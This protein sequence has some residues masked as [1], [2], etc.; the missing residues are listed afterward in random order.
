MRQ[1]GAGFNRDI[2][3]DDFGF[4]LG[5]IGGIESSAGTAAQRARSTPRSNG[6]AVSR[7]SR[8]GTNSRSS[9]QE[10]THVDENGS[11]VKKRKL[12]QTQNVVA[13]PAQP[14]ISGIDAAAA[15]ISSQKASTGKKRGKRRK[16]I[17]QSS[18]NRKRSSVI[19][20]SPVSGANQA[21][22]AQVE[23]PQDDAGEALAGDLTIRD[24]TV[25]PNPSDN[26]DQL[27]NDFLVNT[28]GAEQV[29]DADSRPSDD[30]TMKPSWRR[31][32]KARKSTGGT[33]KRPLPSKLAARTERTTANEQS[34]DEEP[35]VPANDVQGTSQPLDN[36]QGAT[37][38]LNE[39]LSE[40]AVKSSKIVK[41][42]AKRKSVN[43]I[44]HERQKRRASLESA[45]QLAG[46]PETTQRSVRPAARKL[47]LHK[48]RPAPSS[49]TSQHA[50]GHGRSL[51]NPAGNRKNKLPV[52]PTV[53]T[54]HTQDPGTS[55]GTQTKSK[56]KPGSIEI[57]VFR[58]KHPPRLT[59]IAEEDEEEGGSKPTAPENKG[60]NAIDALAQVC[61]EIVRNQAAA[62]KS[63][64]EKA[65]ARNE[66][67]SAKRQFSAIEAFGQELESRF[68]EMTQ[69]LDH[70]VSVQSQLRTAKKT[71][72][73]LRTELL[74]SR[75]EENE[76]A[77][78]AYKLQKRHQL[79][80]KITNED[81]RLVTLYKKL[82]RAV[83]D[84]RNAQHTDDDLTPEG[85]EYD[86]RS[87]ERYSTA[88][89]R[90]GLLGKVQA[91]N[92]GLEK[93]VNGT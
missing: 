52:R 85:L 75:R 74:R 12:S 71:W 1:R 72:K 22:P 10:T 44:R 32:L 19:P 55:Q 11:V 54:Q 25:G 92:A 61:G 35:P 77:V 4:D 93:M 84:A 36:I 33:S 14:H 29:D 62:A 15:P 87:A 83:R 40:P 21:E 63:S 82:G 43:P 66:K 27:D 68:F 9:A 7:A 53:E 30:V 34:T 45:R 64:E 47:A 18:L 49:K 3:E 41:R 81:T 37:E 38:E 51:L 69:A 26:A 89:Q 78:E 70:H 17:S 56:R 65:T 60:P 2:N 16:K 91:F 80:T 76:S 8:R 59:P 24:D 5:G 86:L 42:K 58:V 57:T 79:A 50:T 20:K 28:K 73:G 13:T 48:S 31:Q 46:P 39:E 88:G 67:A 6:S 90:Q 23:E